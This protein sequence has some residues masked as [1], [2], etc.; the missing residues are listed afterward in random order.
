MMPQDLTVGEAVL[1]PREQAVGLIY[2]VYERG[3]HERP[4]VQLLLSDGR[5]LSGFSAE[6]ADQFLQTVGH[7]GLE[8]E[9]R[10][11]GQLHADYQR[12]VFEQAFTTAQLLADFREIKYLQS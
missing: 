1:Y 7:T 9:F 12:G 11:V 2:A 8:Y 4:G 3:T 10:H 6:E 5:D